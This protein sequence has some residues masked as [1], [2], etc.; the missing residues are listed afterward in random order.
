VWS[1]SP[2]GSGDVNLTNNAAT[3]SQP[4]WQPLR[5]FD[6]YPRPGGG[7]PLLTYLVPA[8]QRCIS[9]N[10]QHVGPL[11]EGSCSPPVQ[12]SNLLTTSKVGQGKGFVR[13]DTVAGNP[14]TQADEADL[15]I[16][17]EITDVRNASDES[18][19]AGELVLRIRPRVTDRAG[20]GFAGLSVTA[21]DFRFDVPISCSPT[22]QAPNGS[23]CSISTTADVLWPGFIREGERMVVA[24]LDIAVFD[25]GADGDIG[26]PPDCPRFCGTGDEQRYLEQGTFTP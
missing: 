26:G 13:L 7:T 16:E 20:G 1:I 19:Y 5:A 17:S 22:A 12:V 6:P 3:E 11:S 10:S 2:D 24:T 23:D 21:S 14:G 25:A 9:P 15:K 18:D 4:D 8:Y